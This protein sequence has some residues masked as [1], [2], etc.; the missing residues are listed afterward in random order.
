LVAAAIAAS[1]AIT[2]VG[3]WIIHRRVPRI[4]AGVGTVSDAD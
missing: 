3:G 4:A 2:S 1:V